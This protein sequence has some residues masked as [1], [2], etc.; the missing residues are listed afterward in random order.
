MDRPPNFCR[1][2]LFVFSNRCAYLHTW[3]LKFLRSSSILS[4]KYAWFCVNGHAGIYQ[5]FIFW[6]SLGLKVD[7][8]RG[9][10]IIYWGPTDIAKLAKLFVLDIRS[11][12]DENLT[13]PKE[14]YRTENLASHK[15][16][17]SILLKL[18][19]IFILIIWRYSGVVFTYKYYKMIYISFKS[20]TN[21][22]DISLK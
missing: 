21:L 4:V 9:P 6:G 22:I 19:L 11:S 20:F 1:F 16:P 15:L 5:Y 12:A 7:K 17:F 10:N 8:V 13:G 2:C 14:I 3:T 18:F